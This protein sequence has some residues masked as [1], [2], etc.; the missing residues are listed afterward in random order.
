MRRGGGR[1]PDELHNFGSHLIFRRFYTRSDQNDI[2]ILVF[3]KKWF[4]S[5]SVK[6]HTS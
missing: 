3:H 6:M 5:K 2:S 4:N 1:D